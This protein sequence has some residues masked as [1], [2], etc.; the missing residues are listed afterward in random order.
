MSYIKPDF[1]SNQEYDEALRL[2][3][4]GLDFTKAIKPPKQK[5]SWYNSV[6]AEASMLEGETF[7]QIE[8]PNRR[9]DHIVITNL[10]RI[11]NTN[12]GNMSGVFI[13]KNN[14]IVNLA[15]TSFTYKEL[16]EDTEFEYD[17]ETIKNNFLNN[18]WP[19]K[20]YTQYTK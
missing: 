4:N 10:G 19:I 17:Y 1:I 14:I 6:V 5:Q 3:Y 7:E 13:T 16:F 2:Y 20:K 9:T 15:G 8:I 18:K 12:T 11:I